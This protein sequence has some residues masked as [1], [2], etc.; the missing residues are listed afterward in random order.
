ML[1]IDA[2][3]SPNHGPRR[4]TDRP[5]MVVLHHTAMTSAAAALERLSDPAVEVSAHY[6]L[7]EDGRVWQLVEESRRAWHAGRAAWGDVSDVNSHSIGIE[8][9]NPGDSPQRHPF[10]E[11]QM[12]ALEML[13]AGVLV[14][15]AIP[16]ERVVG[17][18]CV[19]PERKADPGPRFDW[20]R[21]ALQGLSV[22]VSPPLPPGTQRAH[23]PAP[24]SAP[25]GLRGEHI[26][27]GPEGGAGG[28]AS[29]GPWEAPSAKAFQNAAQAF[30]YSV[31][32]TGVWDPASHA[33]WRAFALRFRPFET[34][35]PP[36]AG[37]L[38]QLTELAE[39]WPVLT[40]R[41]ADG[42]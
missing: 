7:G 31:P 13:L 19:A 26:S 32:L 6:V 15:W 39:R 35:A 9:A 20:R 29:S 21:L 40:S 10:P 8:L 24:R 14:R 16:P 41:A 17:H 1:R 18:A 5:D 27:H 23:P 37:G 12:A 36:S 42:D 2:H 30:G 22:W 33:V 38:A 4:G 34:D 25:G 3:P 28:W 11:P